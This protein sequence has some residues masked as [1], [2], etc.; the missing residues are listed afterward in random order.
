METELRG[1]SLGEKILY[2]NVGHVDLLSTILKSV[3][4]AVCVLLQE[5]E[6]GQVVGETVGAQVPENP[7]SWLFFGEKESA[8]IAGE[9]LNSR[10][11][12]DEIVVGTEIAHLRLDESFLHA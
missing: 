12:R 10:T 4:P 5:V 6:P 9:L 7:Y 3:K 11:N 2:I 1:I 8:E